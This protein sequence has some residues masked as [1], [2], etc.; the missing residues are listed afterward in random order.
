MSVIVR[1]VAIADLFPWLKHPMNPAPK[2]KAMPKDQDSTA[3]VLALV[4][5]ED[6]RFRVLVD[7]TGDDVAELFISSDAFESPFEDYK[8]SLTMKEAEELRDFLDAAIGL[9]RCDVVS[10]SDGE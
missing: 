4:T 6:V 1:N 3:D 2:E 7:P 9:G 5:N 10:G 8:V